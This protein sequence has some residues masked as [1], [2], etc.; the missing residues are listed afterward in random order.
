MFSA[1]L[2]VTIGPL[3]KG[4]RNALRSGEGFVYKLNGR[5][6]AWLMPTAKI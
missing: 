4:L 2:N 1:E 5:G 6:T 3:V